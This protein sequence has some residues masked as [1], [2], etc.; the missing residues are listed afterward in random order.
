MEKTPTVLTVI[1]LI[2]Y[3]GVN[4]KSCTDSDESMCLIKEL[5]NVSNY[6]LLC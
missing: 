4:L 3:L 6:K 1:A 5:I 2:R